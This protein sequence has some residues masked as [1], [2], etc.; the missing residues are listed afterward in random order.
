[1]TPKD[2][3][4]AGLII[5]GLLGFVAASL[6]LWRETAVPSPPREVER[7]QEHFRT[8]EREL[9]TGDVSHLTPAQ[10]TARSHHIEVL[11][12]Y[13]ESGV[14]PKNTNHPGR[15]VPYFEDRY[16]TLCAVGYLIAE[17]GRSDI[18]DAVANMMNNATVLEIAAQHQL[19]PVLAD[20]LRE[21]GLTLDEAQRIQPAY[22]FVPSEDEITS[23]YA[24]GSVLIDG[25]AVVSAVL[26]IADQ[27]NGSRL[28]GAVGVGSG[29]TGMALGITKFDNSGEAQ[30]LGFINFVVGAASTVMGVFNLLGSDRE[31]TVATHSEKP[32][33]TPTFTF[34]ASGE[35]RLGV[36]V[37]F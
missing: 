35:P 33:A 8:V 28:L 4:T 6:A 21:A 17:S 25:V 29:L 9:L 5:A 32:I 22:A 3:V 20:W 1:M 26:N 19:G 14:F 2:R 30:T 37:R 15:R 16:G 7:L 27:P 31:S 10:R 36:R 18:V 13:A 12:A 23:V 34:T 11:H 24:V